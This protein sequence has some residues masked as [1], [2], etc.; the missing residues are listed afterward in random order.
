MRHHLTKTDKNQLTD[1]VIF[2]ITKDGMENSSREFTYEKIKELINY[3]T[4]HHHRE[5]IFMDAKMDA[6]KEA[7]YLGVLNENAHNFDASEV[8]VQMVYEVVRQVVE[9]HRVE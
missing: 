2:V 8:G 1:R 4:E 6:I 7:G 3:Q 5:F 9:K